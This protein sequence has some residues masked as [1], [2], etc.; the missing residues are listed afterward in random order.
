MERK[1][2]MPEDRTYIK[3]L[4]QNKGQWNMKGGN[5]GH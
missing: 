5:T 1:H 4:N 2:F 3:G